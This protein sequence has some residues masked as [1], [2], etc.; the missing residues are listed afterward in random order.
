M[1]EHLITGCELPDDTA[2]SYKINDSARTAFD[3]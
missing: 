3:C 1:S 2:V